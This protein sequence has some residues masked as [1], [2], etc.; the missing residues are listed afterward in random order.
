MTETV[1]PDVLESGLRVVFCG[2]AA[3]RKSAAVGA[4]YA[5]V[6]NRF[7]PT[8]YQIGLT[9]RQ[10]APSE[11]RE[12]L[13]YGIGLTD[14][15]QY[16]SGMDKDLKRADFAPERFRQK[17]IDIVPS[18]VAFTSKFSA[19]VYFGVKTKGLRYGLQDT[20]IGLSKIFVLPSPSGAARGHWDE[21]VWRALA[22][23]VL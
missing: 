16:A 10:L 9:P 11:F 14:L 12:A 17:I 7:W 15:A 22:V 2:T 3:G 8:L 1:L 21:S 13:Q 20:L 6:G 23:A 5:G 18:A 4:Y 19:S